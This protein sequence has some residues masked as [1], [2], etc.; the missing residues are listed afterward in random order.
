M[1][2]SAA[3][4]FGDNRMRD[5]WLVRR[6]G[7]ACGVLCSSAGVGDLGR[8]IAASPAGA[9]DQHAQQDQRRQPRRQPCAGIGAGDVYGLKRQRA[10]SSGY[11]AERGC[12]RRQDAA[13]C[14]GD[15]ATIM[16]FVARG[17]SR[18]FVVLA[19]SVWRFFVLSDLIFL[20]L[21]RVPGPRVRRFE[22]D[23]REVRRAVD[24]RRRG[25]K[26]RLVAIAPA[27]A[28]LSRFGR[29]HLALG[30]EIGFGVPA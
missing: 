23:G 9:E 26:R 20:Q 13:R 3:S 6:R 21:D 28:Q 12:E 17:L 14:P 30:L 29:F 4:V 18:R 7:I 5:A 11:G 19:F 27:W 22:V 2:S 15:V 25:L 24:L 8:G 1:V 16:D 10:G